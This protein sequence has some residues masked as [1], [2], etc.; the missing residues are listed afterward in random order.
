MD[1][2]LCLPILRAVAADHEFRAQQLG[3]HLPDIDVTVVPRSRNAKTHRALFPQHRRARATRCTFHLAPPSRLEAGAP[4]SC[5][6]SLQLPR[7]RACR[8]NCQ[9]EQPMQ[10]ASQMHS[11]QRRRQARGQPGRHTTS[12]SLPLLCRPPAGTG[13]S[14]RANRAGLVSAERGCAC[15]SSNSPDRQRY[16]APL[17]HRKARKARPKARP[18]ARLTV[19]LK[20]VTLC[21]AAWLIE[22][23]HQRE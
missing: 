17:V 6:G 16:G 14:E 13:S 20:R 9:W 15:R 3:I 8:S 10:S 22:A 4:T 11:T 18:K 2:S 5:A 1:G 21:R 7:A 19:R 23:A 12:N